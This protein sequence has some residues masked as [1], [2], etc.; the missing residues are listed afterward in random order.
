MLC[1]V[2]PFSAFALEL[3]QS[4]VAATGPQDWYGEDL[5]NSDRL[6]TVLAGADAIV[7]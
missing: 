4:S 5:G 2:R 1:V 7:F 6:G 3:F